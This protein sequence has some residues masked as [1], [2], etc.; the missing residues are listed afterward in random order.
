MLLYAITDR[1][2]LKT[3]LLDR[4]ALLLNAGIDYLQIREKDLCARELLALVESAL[5]LPNPHGARILVNERTDVALA[6]G[7][8]GVHLPSHSISPARLR[9][10]TPPGFVIGVSCHSADE[11][12]RAEQEGADFAVF[13]PIFDTPSKRE[14][15]PPLG[16]CALEQ[17]AR[18]RRIPVLA[19]G[20][21]SLENFQPCRTAGGIAAISLFQNSTDPIALVQVLRRA[22]GLAR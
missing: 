7:A 8:H 2:Q 22:P 6:G 5:A 3:P 20:G 19:L 10:V 1:K 17:A 18:G 9:A 15:G 13:G 21:V 16:T 4:I 14:Y 12:F 11:V